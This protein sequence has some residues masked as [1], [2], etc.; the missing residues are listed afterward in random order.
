VS[1][2]RVA[3]VEDEVDAWIDQRIAHRDGVPA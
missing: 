1:R 2:G 3:W